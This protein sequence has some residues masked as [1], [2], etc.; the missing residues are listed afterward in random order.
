MCR[1]FIELYKS[2]TETP[3]HTQSWKEDFQATREQEPPDSWDM[4][5]Q[6]GAA[7]PQTAVHKRWRGAATFI[8]KVPGTSKKQSADG[9]QV[10]S[11]CVQRVV[12]VAD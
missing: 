2:D 8:P 3:P 11:V 6:D 9:K 12:V 4:E 1:F 5:F 7:S 10:K